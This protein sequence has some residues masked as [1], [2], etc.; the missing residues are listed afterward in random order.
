MAKA[1][2]TFSPEPNERQKKLVKVSNAES[3]A[4]PG[5]KY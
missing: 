2:V 5:G 1:V 4:S 3:C